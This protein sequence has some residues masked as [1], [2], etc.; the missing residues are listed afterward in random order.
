MSK[1][2]AE[3]NPRMSSTLRSTWREDEWVSRFSHA[4]PI[5]SP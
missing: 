3:Q 4:T 5:F 1:A 2:A